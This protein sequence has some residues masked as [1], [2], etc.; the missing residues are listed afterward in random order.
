MLGLKIP[1]MGI[2][3]RYE[4]EY[5][6]LPI[7]SSG[8][9]YRNNPNSLFKKY[10]NLLTEFVSHDLGR[11]Y[12]D[13]PKFNKP[14]SL[15][16]P[17]GFHI[18]ISDSRKTAEGFMWVYT[19][20]VYSP[21]LTPALRELDAYLPHI[22]DSKEAL[23]M[24][25]WSL[26][27]SKHRPYQMPPRL[28]LEVMFYTMPDVNPDADPETNSFDGWIQRSGVD[29]TLANIRAEAEG[30]SSN[31]SSGNAGVA[32]L[33]ASTTTN[34][35]Q[36]LLRGGLLFDASS[37]PDGATL[38]AS[39]ISL[40]IKDINSA[41][42][43]PDLDIV[44]LTTNSDTEWTS[45][46]YANY[47]STVFASILQSNLTDETYEAWTLSEAGRNNISK[48]IVSKFGVRLDWDTDN[49]F[50]GTW[51]SG[52]LNRTK[53]AYADLA[54]N[55]P[56]LVN[57]YTSVAVTL[58]EAITITDS[59]TAKIVAKIFTETITIVASVSKQTGK[60]FTDVITIVAS[61]TAFRTFV[62]TLTETIS[63]TDSIVKAVGK[64]FGDTITVVA[65]VS[66][67]VSRT[68]SDTITVVASV[69]KIQGKLLL[70]NISIDDSLVKAISRIFVNSITV[71]ASV[72]KQAGK[73]FTE[74][75]TI[76]DSKL[77]TYIKT[78]TETITIKD[79]IRKWLNGLLYTIWDKTVKPT[80]TYTKEPKPT[81][82]WTKEA[83]PTTIWTKEPKPEP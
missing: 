7:K 9:C 8:L 40:F 64:V 12:L 10:A 63:I 22:R 59:A 58:T 83:K 37:L 35:F 6:H 33:Q 67:Q 62:K 38:S 27:L 32:N 24:L 3:Y 51:A 47:G 55:P 46:D 34:Q 28:A 19:R 36:S 60:V 81:A 68:F 50:N 45:T 25:F 14:I 57:T 43:D 1:R 76:T 17:N 4:K 56:K 16:L 78:F 21:K 79:T 73:I 41:L 52:N 70:E 11:D 39:V 54:L 77:V 75:L 26:G 69:I 31:S 44:S 49:N 82:T 2:L 15:M 72:L 48:T 71:T 74:N 66:K 29:M 23:E 42:G 65:S 18:G 30:N 80:A 61:S 20:P 5:R 53:I 13:I